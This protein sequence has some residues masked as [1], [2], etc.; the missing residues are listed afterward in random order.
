MPKDQKTEGKKPQGGKP[1]G[2]KA[3]GEKP[4]KTYPLT[5]EEKAAQAKI[6]SLEK[7]L[8]QVQGQVKEAMKKIR[9]K[10]FTR[11]KLR[12]TIQE[13]RDAIK[14]IIDQIEE[15]RNAQK[16]AQAKALAYIDALRKRRNRRAEERAELMKLLPRD[17][18]LPP[19]REEEEGPADGVSDYDRAIKIIHQEM[20]RARLQHSTQ[21]GTISQEKKLIS[22]ES[23]WN[24]IIEKIK[25]LEQKAAAPLADLAEVDVMGL[26]ETCRKLK[27]E[28]NELHN[29]CAPHYN[30][31]A[32]ALKQ[33]EEN[34]AEV[35]QLIK[36]RNE[37]F[38]KA[39]EVVAKLNEASFEM[40]KARY[41]AQQ[42]RNQKKREELAKESAEIKARNE[43]Y[44]KKR[45]ARIQKAMNTLPHEREVESCNALL[46]YL[47][48]IAL[49]GTCGT[50]E[51]AAPK[52]PKTKNPQQPTLVSAPAVQLEEASFGKTEMIVSVKSQPVPKVAKKQNKSKNKKKK[53]AAEPAEPKKKTLDDVV[54]VSAVAVNH[55]EVLSLAVPE[56]YGEVEA[57]YN[58]V[59]EKLDAYEKIRAAVKEQHEKSL[60]EAEQKAIEEA[61]KKEEEAKAAKEAAAAEP[62][63]A[64][65]PAAAAAAEETP[66]E[67]Q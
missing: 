42:I 22:Q 57:R 9:D 52:Q 13:N 46:N 4:K 28:I 36:E 49:P 19:L 64:E 54:S 56:T 65:E 24:F 6:E 17:A 30:A 5:E 23:R 8:E 67:S 34:R 35:P 15:K 3:K 41:K 39:K 66:A 58:E 32:E 14:K 43:E 37:I 40:D 11:N 18:E 20:E 51:N 21:S 45:E 38:A 48:S 47:R 16:S 62:A 2:E 50:S 33:I 10:E 29:S 59:K 44:Q 60:K 27:A 61:Q 7:E 55:F 63:A 25:E 26:L 1:Q 31:I 53:A 12:N